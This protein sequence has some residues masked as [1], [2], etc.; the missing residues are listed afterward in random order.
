MGQTYGMARRL[1][2]QRQNWRS[3]FRLLR[4]DR[5]RVYRWLSGETLFRG[6]HRIAGL[7]R[8][9]GRYAFK[10]GIRTLG[11]VSHGC[12]SETY[13]G[14]HRSR[15]MGAPNR[16]FRTGANWSGASLGLEQSPSSL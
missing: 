1:S 8:Q 7:D 12:A 5:G 16:E 6:P 3:G 15:T 4:R 2:E 9:A 11:L 14:H 13:Q 10:F